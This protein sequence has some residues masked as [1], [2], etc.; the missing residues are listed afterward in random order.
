[1]AGK[2]RR[3]LFVTVKAGEG[4]GQARCIWG[5][6]IANESSEGQ[7]FGANLI[8]RRQIDGG[9]EWAWVRRGADS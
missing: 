2:G 7:T 3:R 9:G 1:M 8:Y 6:L 4:K 5:G